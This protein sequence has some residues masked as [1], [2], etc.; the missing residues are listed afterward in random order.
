MRKLLL[1]CIACLLSFVLFAQ[2]NTSWV[3]GLVLDENDRPLTKVSVLILGKRDG[4]STNDS[5][6]FQI[7]VPAGQSFALTFTHTGYTG[8]QKNFYL[9]HGETEQV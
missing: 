5:G 4:V 2:T 3:K 6:R 9:N 7:R 1:V 8:K